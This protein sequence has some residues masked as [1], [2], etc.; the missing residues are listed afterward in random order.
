M[1]DE[2]YSY[3]AAALL[4]VIVCLGTVWFSFTLRKAKFSP[5]FYTQLGRYVL[6]PFLTQ[7]KYLI[8]SFFRNVVSDFAVV[9]S[10]VLMTVVANV[11]FKSVPTETLNVPK[12]FAPTFSC[13]DASC[14]TAWPDD[15]PNLSA[16]YRQRPW[17]V[18]LFDLNGKGWVPL[19]AAGPALLA[20]I[21][22]F[23][24]DG[25]TWHLIN[26]PNHKLTHGDAYNY[27]T[28]IIGIAVAVNSLLGL[29][30]LVAATVRSL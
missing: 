21:L 25:I 12:S 9:I 5:F 19:M 17:V 29:P 28:I 14:T 11:I 15:C 30:W 18:D 6:L 26:A 7:Y 13:C 22:V 2:D 3:L 27:D 8:F 10:I 4:S 20:F 1:D 24:D 23:L 16:P